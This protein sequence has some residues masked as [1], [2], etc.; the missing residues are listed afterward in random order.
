M[1][2]GTLLPFQYLDVILVSQARQQMKRYMKKDYG[3]GQGYE[4]RR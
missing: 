3:R 4:E 1:I 2:F